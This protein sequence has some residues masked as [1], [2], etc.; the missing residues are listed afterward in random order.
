MF[1]TAFKAV[2]NLVLEEIQEQPKQET[3]G[4][5]SRSVMP[6]Q[7]SKKMNAR[8]TVAKYVQQIRNRRKGYN[9]GRT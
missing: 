9:N 4:L 1:D 5:L 7:D 3:T 6:K 8:Q 2:T